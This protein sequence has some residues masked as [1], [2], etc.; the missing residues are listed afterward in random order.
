MWTLFR[1]DTPF[2]TCAFCWDKNEAKE[3]WGSIE[4][5]YY[6]VAKMP[7]AIHLGNAFSEMPETLPWLATLLWLPLADMM[8]VASWSADFNQCLA[9]TISSVSKK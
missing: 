8:A 7:G 9:F 5:G 3:I 6:S 4:A 2:T 1:A